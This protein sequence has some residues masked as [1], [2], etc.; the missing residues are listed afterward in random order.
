MISICFP[1]T[2]VA[3]WFF[4]SIKAGPGWLPELA[5]NPIEQMII[6]GVL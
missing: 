5:L 1:Q 2:K 3:L 6:A 4:T